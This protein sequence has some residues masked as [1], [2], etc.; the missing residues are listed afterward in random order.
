M[1]WGHQDHN[2]FTMSDWWYKINNEEDQ[3]AQGYLLELR[4]YPFIPWQKKVL[5]ERWLAWMHH[6]KVVSYLQETSNE[7]AQKPKIWEHWEKWRFQVEIFDKVDWHA[8]EKA[9]KST[10]IT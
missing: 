1:F 8:K 9:L 4:A 7:Q 3:L 6:R 5:V 2:S 10:P